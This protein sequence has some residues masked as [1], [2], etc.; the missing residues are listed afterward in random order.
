M[1]SEVE[2]PFEPPPGEFSGCR[3]INCPERAIPKRE[4]HCCAER[5]LE[6]K[7]PLPEPFV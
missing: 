6:E 5:R 3:C 7:Y 2:V 4:C 1:A